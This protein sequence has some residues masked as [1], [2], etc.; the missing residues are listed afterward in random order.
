MQ[1]P[2]VLVVCPFKGEV[3]SVLDMTYTLLQ[4]YVTG[5]RYSLVLWDDGSSDNDLNYLY[6]SI[7]NNFG[8]TQIM[9]VK[10]D[11]Q[12]YT[13]TVY[14]I[15]E[16]VKPRLNIDY[17]LLVNSDIKFKVGS[18]FA[19]VNRMNTNPGIAAVGGKILK[20][21]TDEIQHTG[22]IITPDGVKDPYCGLKLDDPSTMNVERRSW[23]NGCCTLFN[24]DI[25]RKEN[26]NFNLEFTPSYF[27]EADLMTEL[28][29]R[30]YSVM[31]EPAAVIEHAVGKTH[32]KEKDKYEKVFWGNWD[33]FQIKW[34]PFYNSPM[35]QF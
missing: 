35:L 25:F 29:M 19:M 5:F 8:N 20:M 16:H 12:G 11:N 1:K 13:K 3:K 31:Y 32:H 22:A 27:E 34:K 9:I 26:L 7:K 15:M 14:D 4:S 30:G 10:H 6:E 18:M 17:L 33:K 28:N 21:G 2:Y 24:L 23:A